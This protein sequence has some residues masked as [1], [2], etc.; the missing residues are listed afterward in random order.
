M[1]WRTTRTVLGGVALGGAL[2]A[3][4]TV[5]G[6]LAQGPRRG[7]EPLGA[8][9]ATTA[10]GPL[11]ATQPELRKAL[12][13]AVDLPEYATWTT[14]PDAG[15]GRGDAQPDRRAETCGVLFERPWDLTG[16]PAGERAEN[17]DR[18]GALLTQT[19]ALL[20]GADRDAPVRR[21]AGAGGRCREFDATLDDGTGVRVR[22][23]EVG[24]D[25]TGYALRFTAATGRRTWYGYVAVGR[26]GPVLSVLRRVGPRPVTDAE[27]AGTLRLA[28]ARMG[29]ATDLRGG[30]GS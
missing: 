17:A 26:L 8:P 13:T 3:T 7:V 5:A 30:P 9:A 29:D 15:D 25:G 1:D 18:G 14:R 28:V 16:E 24:V 6:V 22:T 19:V 10:P 12:L 11:T 27:V 23:A 20:T 21:V 2:L 4:L